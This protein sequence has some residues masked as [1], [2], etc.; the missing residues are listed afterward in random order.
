MSDLTTEV[1]ASSENNPAN[2]KKPTSARAA[3]RCKACGELVKGHPGK[4]GI[5]KCKLV[6]AAESE[7]VKAEAPPSPELRVPEKRSV[8]A[9]LVDDLKGDALVDD[10]K[11]A[12]LADELKVVSI[13]REEAGASI[14][15]GELTED[16]IERSGSSE[17]EILEESLIA[18]P[19]LDSA[20]KKRLSLV[21]ERVASSSHTDFDAWP[22]LSKRTFVVCLCGI[23]DAEHNCECPGEVRFGKN[24]EEGGT[25]ILFPLFVD[26][27]TKSNWMVKLTLLDT[28]QPSPSH[29]LGFSLGLEGQDGGVILEG[30][31]HIEVKRLV[32]REGRRMKVSIRLKMTMQD[33]RIAFLDAAYAD[34]GIETPRNLEP[35]SAALWELMDEDVDASPLF[36]HEASGEEDGVGSEVSGEADEE[37]DRIEESEEEELEKSPGGEKPSKE[38]EDGEYDEEYEEDGSW[39]EDDSD[40]TGSRS[41]ESS[42][43]DSTSE[44]SDEGQSDFVEV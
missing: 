34:E 20:R 2:E 12:D 27:L 25:L 9:A 26:P 41:L 6:V 40:E 28:A 35:V 16:D 4:T 18:L 11:V 13:N 17:D 44:S 24:L 14:K 31:A 29:E 37:V 19:S 10:L 15:A 1:D 43:Q 30:E 36:G 5:G 39:R 33:V 32:E 7:D 21:R 38:N 3:P 8:V 42:S 23:D 22:F